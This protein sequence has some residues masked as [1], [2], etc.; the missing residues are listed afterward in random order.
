MCIVLAW[1]S[2]LELESDVE[3]RL[4]FINGREG[5]RDVGGGR[6]LRDHQVSQGGR[7]EEKEKYKEGSVFRK[8]ER[9]I[10]KRKGRRLRWQTED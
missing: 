2:S 4:S 1:H 10:Q 9:I 3:E 5:G 7:R 6:C 8:L